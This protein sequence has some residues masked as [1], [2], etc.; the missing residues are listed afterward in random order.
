MVPG[1]GGKGK[2]PNVKGDWG[3]VIGMTS[4]LLDSDK[5]IGLMLIGW[6]L[7]GPTIAPE[8]LRPKLIG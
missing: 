8:L 1:A 3:I 6:I 7:I 5:P 2:M 4:G